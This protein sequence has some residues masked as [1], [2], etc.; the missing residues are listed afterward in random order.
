MIESIVKTLTE[1]ARRSVRQVRRS[2]GGGHGPITRLVSP[3]D[4][5]EVLKPFVFLDRFAAPAS[6]VGAMP[7]HPHSGIATITVLTE[8]NA[9]FDDP[10]SGHG[11]MDYAGVEWMRASN[12]VWHGK[13]MSAGTSDSVAGFQL[14]IALPPELENAVPDSQYVES[15]DIPAIG[16]ARLVLGNYAGTQSPVRSPRGVNYI[17]IRLQPGERW[18]YNTPDDHT[19]AWLAVA[20]G[21]LIGAAP[22]K[23]GDLVIFDSGPGII[24][25]EAAADSKTVFVLG[26]A[27]AHPHD[28]VL[29]NYSV[30]TTG[31]ALARGEAQITRLAAELRQAGDRR[32]SG[33]MPVYR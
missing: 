16:P 14:W 11:T 12:G 15:S 3:S 31:D 26:S 18:V 21:S 33:A 2:T 10:E 17:M 25:V 28:L 19:V 9:R 30:H 4:L 7:L 29:G 20:D 23:A 8:G 5:G 22:A 1:T 27:V 6:F 32:R 13:E 24:E